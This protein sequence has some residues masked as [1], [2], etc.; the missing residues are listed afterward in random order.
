MN[1][2]IS[3]KHHYLPVH[4]LEG[5][6][7]GNNS[8]FV[9][10]KKA[11]EIFPTNPDGAFFENNLNTLTLPNG[12][13]SNFME[14]YYTEI[15]NES[16]GSINKIRKS[17]YKT[18]IEFTDKIYLY[19]FLL[20]LYW[21]LPSNIE[22]G[23]KLSEKAFLD[24][25]EVDFFKL[26]SKSGEKVPDG[27]ADIIKNSPAFKKSFKQ[28]I[29]FI[30]FYKDK[31]WAMSL[32]KWRFL[33]TGDNK[34]L[35]IVGDNPF[36]IKEGNE[37]DLVNCLKEFVCPISGNILLISTSEPTKSVLPPEFA[38][39]YN[40]AIIERAQRFVACKDKGFLEALI[41]YYKIHIQY[42]KTNIIIPEMFKMMSQS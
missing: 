23:E 36:I 22:F 34:S 7:D 13:S 1:N 31:D 35:Y 40:T 41:N 11:D 28:I 18:T 10:D 8:F 12:D 37:H 42:G 24:N 2:K 32:G 21:R 14:S 4:Y 5:F 38:N 3:K 16:W 33:Y 15:E 26:K 6:T 9:Y 30:P 29:P 25:N 17:N 20:F 19:S 39:D 27:V